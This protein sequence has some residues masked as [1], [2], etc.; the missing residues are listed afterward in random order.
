MLSGCGEKKM[1]ESGNECTDYR[2]EYDVRHKVGRKSGGVEI[3]KEHGIAVEERNMKSWQREKHPSQLHPQSCFTFSPSTF[4]HLIWNHWKKIKT[5]Q[6]GVFAF[7]AALFVLPC[8]TLSSL[9][10]IL[11][12]SYF[13]HMYS[14]CFPSSFAILSFFYSCNCAIRSPLCTKWWDRQIFGNDNCC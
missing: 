2:G 11:L 3:T 1:K 7:C 8:P 13:M 12:I 5:E 4:H 14:F 6:W 10:N 9:D